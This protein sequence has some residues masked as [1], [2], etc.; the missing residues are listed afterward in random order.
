MADRS[1]AEKFSV[2]LQQKLLKF[3]KNRQNRV[4]MGGRG[5]VCMAIIYANY[6]FT[7]M[8][9]CKW[10]W[11]KGPVQKIVRFTKVANVDFLT[12]VVMNRLYIVNEH[13][14]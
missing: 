9:K 4:N 14:W 2:F 5:C 10:Y 8:F 3:A 6:K 12:N 11:I 7:P 1:E 13:F